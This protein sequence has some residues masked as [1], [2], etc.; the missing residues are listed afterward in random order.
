[1]EKF[2]LLPTVLVQ[3]R[4]DHVL[5]LTMTESELYSIDGDAGL[6][7]KFIHKK[8]PKS[9][10][11]D[12]LTKYLQTNSENFRKNPAQESTL[13][14]ALGHFEQLKLILNESKV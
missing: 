11:F 8:Y 5:V 4:Q 3:E 12:D 2:K 10:S 6:A 14:E 7:L 9:A 1:M 13:L